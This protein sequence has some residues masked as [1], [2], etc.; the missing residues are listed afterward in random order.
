MRD[1]QQ[2]KNRTIGDITTTSMVW[3]TMSF[4]HALFQLLEI[5]IDR[6]RE[7]ERVR[8]ENCVVHAFFF[9]L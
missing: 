1:G 9:N 5:Y 3:A 4:R 8:A 6:G 2:F 7:R